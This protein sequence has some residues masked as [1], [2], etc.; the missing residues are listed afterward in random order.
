MIDQSSKMGPDYKPSHERQM[1]SSASLGSDMIWQS[2]HKWSDFQ[3]AACTGGLKNLR[4][5]LE[6]N[7]TVDWTCNLPP[8]VGLGGI[9]VRASSRGGL[10]VATLR[11][12]S[13]VF[14]TSAAALLFASA[15]AAQV[16][17]IYSPSNDLE[18]KAQEILDKHCA[19][20]HQDGKLVNKEKPSKG[21]G[22]VM[23]LDAL[24]GN[25]NRVRAGN[26]DASPMFQTI[27][28][29]QMPYD[30]YQEGAYD[31]PSPTEA[32][33][34]TLREWI[35]KGAE[36]ADAACKADE[37]DYSYKAV[38]NAM[39]QDIGNIPE[40]RRRNTRYISLAHLKAA[41]TSEGDMEIYRQGVIRLLNSLSTNSDVITLQDSVVKG[42]GTLIRFNLDDLFWS[43]ELWEHIISHYPYGVRPVDSQYDAL[44]NTTYTKI[45]YVRGD[46]LAFFGAR[47][48]LYEKILNLPNTF[49]GLEKALGLDTFANIKNYTA[50]R[51]GFKDSG[52]SAH[53]RLIERHTIATG[54]F[55]T[56][57]DFAGTKDQ[58][59]LKEFPLGPKGA[60]GNTYSYGE[61][62]AFE[63]DG[64]ESIFNLPNG[65]QAYYLNTADGA[66]LAQGPTAIVQDRSRTDL[67]VTNGISCMGCHDQGMK[68]ATDEIRDH[69]ADNRLLPIEVREA[70]KALY[71]ESKEMDKLLERDRKR[72]IDALV[73]SG[74]DPKLKQVT[75][76]E[77]INALSNRYERDVDLKSAAAEFGVDADK[78]EDYL[79]GG[80]RVGG[81]FAAQLA[82]STVQRDI[83]EKE[84]PKL[85]EYV[86]DGLPIIYT[87]ETG[88]VEKKVEENYSVAEVKKKEVI[89]TPVHEFKI[90]MYADKAKARVNETT[91]FYV[92]TTKDCYLTLVNVS[93]KG[94]GT[95]ILPNKFTK[96]NYIKAGEEFQFPSAKDGYDFK[97]EDYGTET[98]IALCDT[99][100][101][102]LPS[103]VHDFSKED[104][105]N[106][107]RKISVVQKLDDVKVTKKEKAKKGGGGFPPDVAR[108]AIK[109][110][111][112]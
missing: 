21:F 81:S 53:N 92:K 101:D 54:A 80:G 19:R 10:T 70:V 39:Y 78:I 14:S 46:W 34:S 37:G 67:A 61:T 96:D 51:A 79:R 97:F 18:K 50:K 33:L 9:T 74:L 36:S 23:Q 2:W 105:T 15:A 100:G 111:V 40:S 91:S 110:E 72:F 63:H 7:F 106:L 102:S 58:Q 49:Q 41:C 17:P 42:D 44:V 29:K 85:V 35:E 31:K 57:Y 103:I 56:S 38:V 98:V 99:K 20:C 16:T 76:G 82:Q 3:L 112:Q 60:F 22:D 8:N 89:E 48:P 84:F 62:L 68:N 64:G 109:I 83:F 47:P 4:H 95:V 88:Y 75:D 108:T 5:G 52:V 77:P 13:I 93:G 71:P 1:K 90:S 28:N 32:E 94:E 27:V 86:I 25:T 65:Y 87:G 107:G 11:I 30:V 12:P 24:I 55:W 104:F 69:V 43:A 26:P 45:P 66:Q 59:N 6:N 73:N